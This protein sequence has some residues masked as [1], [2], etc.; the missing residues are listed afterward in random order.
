MMAIG[1]AAALSGMKKISPKQLN[2]EELQKSLL[3]QNMILSME[4]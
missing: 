4:K 3:K 2:L 1:Q